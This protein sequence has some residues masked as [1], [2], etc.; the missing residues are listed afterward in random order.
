MLKVDADIASMTI[1]DVFK[2]KQ[3]LAIISVA[4]GVL[5]SD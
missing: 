4:T 3:Q 5:Q 2:V 1:T